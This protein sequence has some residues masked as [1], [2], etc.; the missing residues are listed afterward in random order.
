[1]YNHIFIHRLTLLIFYDILISVG[2]YSMNQYTEKEILLDLFISEEYLPMTYFTHRYKYSERSIRNYISQLRDCGLQIEYK[3]N[4]GYYFIHEKNSEKIVNQKISKI[5]ILN[6]DRDLR[7]I[8]EIMILLT[9]SEYVSLNDIAQR[10]FISKTTAKNDMDIIFQR[11]RRM[12]ITIKKTV[13]GHY[14][15]LTLRDKVHFL[16]GF[17]LHSQISVQI[18]NYMFGFVFNDTCYLKVFKIVISQI[19]DLK[20]NLNDSRVILFVNYL[21][22]LKYLDIK[23]SHLYDFQDDSEIRKEF[24]ALKQKLTPVLSLSKE[25]W[26]YAECMYYAFIRR[27]PTQNIIDI[28]NNILQDFSYICQQ[29]YKLEFDKNEKQLLTAIFSSWILDEFL[30]VM[31]ENILTNEIKKTYIESYEIAN[32]LIYIFEANGY[33]C[34]EAEIAQ[35]SLFLNEILVNRKEIFSRKVHLILLND[36]DFI[37]NYHLC[38]G[39]K[40]TIDNRFFDMQEMSLYKFHQI[41]SN[42]DKNMTLVIGT[43]KNFISSCIVNHL[44][45]LVVNPLL[46]GEDIQSINLKIVEKR[47]DIYRLYLLQ[48]LESC[49]KSIF[50][51]HCDSVNFYDRSDKFRFIVDEGF[52]VAQSKECDNYIEVRVFNKAILYKGHK[53]KVFLS[54]AFDLNT[55]LGENIILIKNTIVK[56]IS[57]DELLKCSHNEECIQL[58]KKSIESSM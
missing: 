26:Q 49:E 40:N 15:D 55:S 48:G 4:K 3:R 17:I 22:L 18:I 6:S 39:I 41:A 32:E 52:L 30:K 13:T 54:Y 11:F 29:Q 23:E 47:R 20:M 5:S 57:L 44:S 7:L 12:N 42:I 9:S 51:I 10:L 43:D 34:L 24:F 1:M 45:Y 36:C 14:V 58:I 35:F 8:L 38:K 31:H 37:I 53:I 27:I 46:Y 19:I 28:A 50:L 16:L 2:G 56:N 33:R 25:K 21:L